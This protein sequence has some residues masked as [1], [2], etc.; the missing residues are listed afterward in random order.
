MLRFA[1]LLGAVSV[2]SAIQFPA[3]LRQTV[4]DLRDTVFDSTPAIDSDA[5]ERLLRQ[6]NVTFKTFPDPT[7]TFSEPQFIDG[8]AAVWVVNDLVGRTK[9]DLLENVTPSVAGFSV[10]EKVPEA[11]EAFVHELAGEDSPQTQL[12]AGE[13]SP[14]TQLRAEHSALGGKDESFLLLRE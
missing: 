11:I 12:L 8:D 2:V 3:I 1:F 7:P 14:Q 4:D 9:G 10:P 6:F 13:D 5:A